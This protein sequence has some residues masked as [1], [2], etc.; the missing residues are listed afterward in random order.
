MIFHAQEIW[1]KMK[2]KVKIPDILFAI[3]I[4]GMVA[5]TTG[6]FFQMIKTVQG[7][8]P[9]WLICAELFCILSFSLTYLGWKK[10]PSRATFQ[11]LITHCGW[12]LSIL[13][14]LVLLFIKAHE[15][16][17]GWYDSVTFVFVLIA[18][19]V[20][21][22]W[23]LVARLGIADPI[24]RGVLAGIYRGVPHVSLAYKIWLLGGRGIAPVTIW[25]AN[26]TACI[27]IL[28]LLY[29]I[30]EAGLDRTRK[31]LLLGECAN[32]FTWI[33]VT[34]VWIIRY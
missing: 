5:F 11:L 17:W 3:Q 32:E 20:I 28:Q 19:L 8:S 4:L 1:V 2:E 9:A 12:M 23:A 26:I 16:I 13:L 22:C 31:G 27:R 10:T 33:L 6:Q 24:V 7:I 25:A 21:L 30:R 18:T 29:A 15:V 14:L 34:I